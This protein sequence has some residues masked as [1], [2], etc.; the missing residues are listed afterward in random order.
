MALTSVPV[1][2]P[3]PAESAMFDFVD[4]YNQSF[5]AAAEA[6]GLSLAQ[7]CILGR[8]ADP[9]G[10]GELAEELGCDASNVTQIVTR[11]EARSLVERRADPADRR[12]RRLSRTPQGDAAV[13]A[14]DESFAFAREALTRLSEEEQGQLAALLRKAL[15]DA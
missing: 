10:M 14:F 8:V 4:A 2:T 5:E 9:R 13:A 7:A 1:A 3:G 12:S 6:N 15:G 11:L